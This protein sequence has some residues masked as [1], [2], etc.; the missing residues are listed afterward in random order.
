MR[1]IALCLLLVACTSAPEVLD[2]CPRNGVVPADLRDVERAGEGLVSATFGPGP[3]HKPDWP[4][5]TQ[6]LA[7]L[8]KVWA[9]GKSTCPGLPIAAKEIDSQIEQLKGAV[10]AKDQALAVQAANAVGLAVPPLF[11][12]F[13][14]D[15]P[16][17]IVRMDAMFRQVGI[18]A[19]AG[20][21]TA[22]QQDVAMLAKDWQASKVAVQK[23]VPTC[24]RVGNTATVVEDIDASLAHL[25][26]V[27]PAQ[28]VSAV[29]TESDNGALEIDTLELLF[30]CPPDGPAPGIGLGAACS[31][32]KPCGGELVCNTDGGLARCGPDPAH[33]KIGIP[34]ETTAE[35]GS[36]PRSACLTDA[37]DGYP[38]GYCGM[39]PCDDV[40]ICPAG[41]T[42]V[43]IGGET[44]GCLAS[45]TSDNDCRKGY[46]C[47]LFD[48]KPPVGFGPSA[49]ACA[50]PCTRDSD[51]RPTAC[52][53][54]C[55][56]ALTCNVAL[57]KCQP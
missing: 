45:C 11:D 53:S 33:D 37:G 25:A 54:E 40:Q 19:Y 22:V 1:S 20:R 30:D 48:T 57:G 4:R 51:C 56:G 27:L 3:D 14:P 8:G 7:L 46:V 15:A 34:C 38:G 16:I 9:R 24:H 35:C 13:H 26:Q 10:A 23:R 2:H 36:D 21:W 12:W 50:F 44:P 42:C 49:H 47:Q 39:E 32:S 28:D 52:T 5:A 55:P 18:D 41:A 43:A 6:V 29:G 31:P 17:E